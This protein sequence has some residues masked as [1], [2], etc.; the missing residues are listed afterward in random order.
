MIEVTRAVDLGGRLRT[1]EWA[2][3]LSHIAGSRA[4]DVPFCATRVAVV[5]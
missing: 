2:K 1:R 5:R 3:A 4:P